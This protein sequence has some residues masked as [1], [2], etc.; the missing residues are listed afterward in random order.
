M[1]IEEILK[2][3]IRF[4][5]SKKGTKVWDWALDF[6]HNK[7][8]E[9]AEVGGKKPDVVDCLSLKYYL[10]NRYWVLVT[11]DKQLKEAAR[12][13]GNKRKREEKI[14]DPLIN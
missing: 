1:N 5:E 8:K 13:E 14:F 4:L 6:S 3:K 11:N 10:D 7:Y 12:K 2:G 9:Y